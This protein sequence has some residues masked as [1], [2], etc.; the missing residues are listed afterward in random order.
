[1]PITLATPDDLDRLLPCMADFNASDGITVDPTQL[2]PALLRLRADP[3]LGRVILDKNNGVT[4]CYAV[5]TWGYDLEYGGRDAWLTEFWVAPTH[6]GRG[7]G[8]TLLAAAEQVCRDHGASALHL[9][10]RPDN[11]PARRLYEG[12]GYAPPPRLTLSRTLGGPPPREP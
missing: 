1:M 7:L 6:R 12:A 10:V 2:R 11:L 3:S 8:R 4:S 5:I 9:M